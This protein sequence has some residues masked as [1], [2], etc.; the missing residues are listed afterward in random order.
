MPRLTVP[1]ALALIGMLATVMYPLFVADA[2]RSKTQLSTIAETTVTVREPCNGPV[3][4]PEVVVKDLAGNIITETYVGA[5]VSIEGTVLFDCVDFANEDQ[6]ITLFEVRT[7]EGITTFIAW[8]VIEYTDGRVVAGQ[9]WT[10]DKPGEY[11]VRLF[12]PVCLNCP[13]VL[14]NVVAYE[15]TVI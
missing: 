15:I 1:A 10:P 4:D 6:R 5:Q 7:K 13:M 11:E 3:V 14:S 8:Q 12:S 9:S 2:V